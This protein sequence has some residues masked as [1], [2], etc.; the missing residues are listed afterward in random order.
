MQCVYSTFVVH[1]KQQQ[2]VKEF[3]LK[4]A[5]HVVPLWRLNGPF[6]CVHRR[7]YSQCFSMNRTNP[8]IAP[9]PWRISTPSDNDSLGHSQPSEQRLDRFIGFCRAH[10]RDQQTDRHTHTHTHTRIHRQIRLHSNRPHRGAGTSW[11]LGV[12]QSS[13]NYW[14]YITVWDKFKPTC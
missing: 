2:V 11:I 10:E 6:C 8:K 12:S 5:S 1:L 13:Q 4:A 3:W 7:R 14:I 9:F